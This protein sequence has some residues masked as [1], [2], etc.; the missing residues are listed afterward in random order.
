MHG[1]LNVKFTVLIVSTI[2][3]ILVYWFPLY[4]TVNFKRLFKS[5]QNSSLFTY[6]LRVFS[7]LNK[8][9]SNSALH[10]NQFPS[11]DTEVH[12]LWGSSICSLKHWRCFIDKFFCLYNK[13]RVLAGARLQSSED[14]LSYCCRVFV[15]SNAIPAPDTDSAPQRFVLFLVVDGTHT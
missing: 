4:F 1:H 3:A 6:L 15:P 5:M 8:F 2:I 14:N 11:H 10:K 7:P 13:I 9:L 12:F